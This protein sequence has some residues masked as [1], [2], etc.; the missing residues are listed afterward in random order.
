[1]TE[2]K[3]TSKAPGS[4]SDSTASIPD[5]KKDYFKILA[6]EIPFGVIMIAPDGRFF[7]INKKF[8]EL[9]GYDLSDTPDGK[10][11]FRKAY[12]DADYRHEVI[13]AW[14]SDLK[15]AKPGE[16]RTRIFNVTCKD[17]TQKIVQFIPVCSEE[18][19]DIVCMRDIT[20]E[21]ALKER[22]NESKIKYKNIFENAIEG[23][24]QSTPES[25]YISVN[26]SY[27]SMFRYESPEEMLEE[28]T[29]IATQCYA[30][31]EDRE[32]FKTLLE[33]N[34]SIKGFESK[35]K[36]KDG[37]FFW[38][39]VNAHVVRDKEGKTLYYEGTLED[40]TEKKLY[41]EEITNLARQ[42][43][44][45]F[46]AVNDAIWILDKDYRIIRAN[47]TSETM[48]NLPLDEISGKHCFEIVHGTYAPIP[49][50][51][52]LK[53]Y[54]TFRR[55]TIELQIGE[56]WYLITVDPI[57]DESGNWAGATHIVSDI[58]S[59]K[60]AE[61][62]LR[63]IEALESS[64]LT[65]IPHAVI[66]L[67]NR[68][69]TL[70]NEGVRTVFGYSPEELIG[71][72]TR[73]LYRSDADYEAI[74]RLSYPI[75][76]RQK[77]YS[78]DFPCQKKDGT[79]ILC[80]VSTAVIGE[81]LKEKQIVVVYEDIT[82]KKKAQEELLK[83][84][85]KF[86]TLVENMPFGIAMIDKKGKYLFVNRKWQEI[87]GYDLKDI[88]DG[89]TWFKKA[90]PDPTYRKEAIKAWVGEIE[91]ITPGEKK[92]Y[93][94]TVTCK[95]K[96]EKIISFTAVKLNYDMYV[97]TYE[98]I[99]QA[100]LTEQQLL[101]AQKMESIGR[102]AGGIA[103][104]FNNMLTVV[105]GHTQLGLLNLESNNPLYHRF[106][107]IQK[108]AKRSS[109]LTKNLLTF[110][111]KQPMQPKVLDVN[112][113]V[114]DMLKM[115]K[116]LIGENIELIWKPRTDLW[117][118]NLDP[119]QLN[120]VILNL[121]INAK[122]AISYKGTITIETDNITLDE[123]YCLHHIGFTPEDYVILCISDNGAGM[124]KETLEHIF[125]PFFTTKPQGVGTGLGLSTVYGIVKQNNGFINVYSELN[126]GSTFKIYF[127]RAIEDKETAK[128]DTKKQILKG[129]E[130]TILLVEDEE[131]VL[132]LCKTML[133][134][135]GYKVISARS[136]KEAIDKAQTFKGKIHL[137]LTDV[138]MPEMDGKELTNQI[139]NI[140]PSIKCLFMSGYTSNAIIHNNILDE[141]L[142]YIQKPFTLNDLA[143]KIR[144]ALERGD[145]VSI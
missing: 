124:D 52:A 22:L 65:A 127:P 56:R 143:L 28:V 71:K 54:K 9:F 116:R 82:E 31:P 142:N 137:L 79:P 59:R 95:D 94:F 111:R 13:S 35:R 44:Q 37:S 96:K 120:Q 89:A 51:P 129:R 103:H 101:Q 78:H 46:D 7:Y 80:R 23:I 109:E 86:S 87:F 58:T 97:M 40:I 43:Q 60:L 57:L 88:P 6:E 25:R 49:Q 138:I 1:M 117:H 8:T 83:E 41:E 114:E 4:A 70:A 145:D 90:F 123:T 67:K 10:T 32:R 17:G 62:T 131:D 34:G 115:L 36:R 121:V 12:P 19:I 29:D 76:E 33:K 18:G 14:I 99:T 48:F 91:D 73:L 135:L 144:Q 132:E 47:K 107:E 63:R 122:D 104:D 2:K 68:I 130:E 119:S 140:M 30:N 50:C 98:D 105:Y 106:E 72:S 27:A 92:P 53:V 102:L 61:D 125:E 21:E 55:E 118:V 77:T 113:V 11:W 66:R 126:K 69:I 64:I 84:K 81:S 45:A 42:W 110:A 139:K 108:A 74:G 75:L 134:E 100:K 93:I 5:Q 24:F 85:E 3:Y 141:G 15:I 112:M 39:K 20:E 128:T 16:K 38:T 136:P 133:G 26:P